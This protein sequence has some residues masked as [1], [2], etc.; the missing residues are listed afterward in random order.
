MRSV[1]WDSE[2][3]FFEPFMRLLPEFSVTQLYSVRSI[4]SSDDYI[5]GAFLT[6][7]IIGSNMIPSCLSCSFTVPDIHDL[8]D[9]NSESDATPSHAMQLTGSA[10]HGGCL[11]TTGSGRAAL[12]L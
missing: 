11:Q 12:R 10:H 9:A 6:S 5:C 7:Y 2:T 4:P 8:C 1:R 3:S